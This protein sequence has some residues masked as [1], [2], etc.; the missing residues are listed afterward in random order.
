MVAKPSMAKDDLMLEQEIIQ[1]AARSPLAHYHWKN[2]GVAP[3]GYTK[4]MAVAWSR[5]YREWKEGSTATQLMASANTHDADSD[6]LSWYAG[7]FNDLDMSN[8]WHGADTLRHLFVLLTGLGM[9]ESSGKFCEGRDRSA[10][11]TTSDTAEAGLFQM[12]WDAHTAS[13]E[14]VKQFEKYDDLEEGDDLVHVFHEGVRCTQNDLQNYGHGTGKLFQE[15]CKSSP[16]CAIM[17]ASVGLRVIRRHWGPISRRE[18]EIRREADQL[19]L[20]IQTMVDGIEVAQAED[21]P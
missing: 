6:A 9:R 16:M 11:N 2:R 3:I 14:I 1:L 4:G 7:V 15:L 18:A 10:G 19:Y 17:T 13:D 20:A 5:V 8:N 12:S 21:A